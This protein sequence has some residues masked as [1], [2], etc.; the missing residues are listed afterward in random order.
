MLLRA[1]ISILAFS[2]LLVSCARHRDVR[3]L[4]IAVASNFKAPA[5]ELVKRFQERTGRVV[6]ITL[7]STGKLYAQIDNGAPF[8]VFLA[9]DSERPRLLEEKL[10]A[11]DGSRFTYAVGKLVLW[12][13]KKGV[14]DPDGKVVEGD[15][16]SKLAIANPSLAPY[17]NAAEEVLR[18]RG[19]WDGLRDRIVRG[20][21]I[22]QAFQ[23]VYSG[24]AE[25]GF[26]ALS[27]VKD[28]GGSIWIV[29]QDLYI[30]IEQQ[31]VLLSED[32]DARRF[33]EFVKSDEAR[34]IIRENGYDTK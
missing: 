8:D 6:T 33:L 25:L 32:P 30:P 16:F 13:P 2:V 29:P 3:E 19:L 7:G 20:E 34:K 18:K 27:Q 11:A 17:G 1:V 24:N 22:G 14:V 15:G 21:N 12:S 9:A 28:K 26:L 10:Q 5:A 31:A 4:R 23:F